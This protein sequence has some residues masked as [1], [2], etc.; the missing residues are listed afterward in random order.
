M[1]I[2]Y[3]EHI[4]QFNFKIEFF[5]NVRCE[6]YSEDASME[7]NN[8]HILIETLSN[9]TRLELKDLN[10]MTRL[11]QEMQRREMQG[12][13]WNLQGNNYLKKNSIKLML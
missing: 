13:G 2:K 3:G 9:L 7:I 12:S 11:D 6:K 10:V 4:R 8:H 1:A 5:S